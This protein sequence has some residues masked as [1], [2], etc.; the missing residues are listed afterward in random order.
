MA[1][2]GLKHAS[3]HALSTQGYSSIRL[4]LFQPR[5]SNKFFKKLLKKIYREHRNVKICEG[6][7]RY[8]TAGEQ[9]C[10]DGTTNKYHD[11]QLQA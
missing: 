6:S 11:I 1:L 7:L 10:E 9:Y 4:Y 3:T 5:K 2:S 8:H